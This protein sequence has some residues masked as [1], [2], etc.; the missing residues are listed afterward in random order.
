MLDAPS[1]EPRTSMDAGR[2]STFITLHLLHYIITV[3]YCSARKS[4]IRVVV[5]DDLQKYRQGSVHVPQCKL[6]AFSPFPSRRFG[7]VSRISVS[8]ATGTSQ[9]Y[10]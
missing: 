7:L 9:S 5:V 1:S 3:H 8:E 10:R 4:T 2:Y 6:W